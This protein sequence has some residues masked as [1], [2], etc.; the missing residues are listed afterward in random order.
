MVIDILL[1]RRVA[2]SARHCLYLALPWRRAVQNLNPD[3]APGDGDAKTDCQSRPAGGYVVTSQRDLNL[4]LGTCRWP[5]DI[6]DKVDCSH[7]DITRMQ[8]WYDTL[9]RLMSIQGTD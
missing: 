9:Y 6:R 5:R 2:A 8:Q 4:L 3:P 1:V 7:G